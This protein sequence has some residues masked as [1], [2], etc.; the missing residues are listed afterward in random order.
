MKAKS[1]RIRHALF[2]C[3]FFFGFVDVS[4]GQAPYIVTSQGAG[5][6]GYLEKDATTWFRLNSNTYGNIYQL[7]TRTYINSQVIL[8]YGSSASNTCTTGEWST[9]N[10]NFGVNAIPGYLAYS[11]VHA[12][13][14][15]GGNSYNSIPTNQG[16]NERQQMIFDVTER[17][18]DLCSQ[19]VQNPGLRDN[20]VLSIKL[21]FGSIT[22]RTLTR[23]WLKNSGT[24]GEAGSDGIANNG[25]MVYY[26]A[27]TG[28][29]IYDGNEASAT[30]Y[31]NYN[32]N[33]TSNNE[34]GHDGL[35]INIPAGG[36]RIYVVLKQFA[37][38]NTTNKT[39]SFQILNDGLSFSPSLDTYTK[40]RSDDFPSAPT[41]ITKN[42]Q[43]TLD[44]AGLTSST[45]STMA[46]SARK[47]SSSYSG[48]ILR[49]YTGSN[50]YDVYADG[51]NSISLNSTISSSVANYNSAISTAT[52][53]LLSSLIT[54]GSNL[55]VAVWYDQSGNNRHVYQAANASRPKIVESGAITK[56]AFGN[57]A[58]KFNYSFLQTSQSSS[59]IAYSG[60]T[61]NSVCE[62]DGGSSRMFIGIDISNSNQGL[63]YGD[64]NSTTF[65]LNHYY[66]DASF[67]I[68]SSTYPRIRTAVKYN[69][70]GGSAAWLN[71]SSLGTNGNPG[72][73]LSPAYEPFNIGSGQNQS[74]SWYGY[75]AEAILFKIELSSTERQNLETNQLS[76]FS[77]SDATWTGAT[78]TDWNTASNWSP[79]AV[80]SSS[81]IINIPSVG[82]TNTPVVTSLTIDSGKSLTLQ[83]NAKLTISGTLTNNGTL[84]LKD[85][86]TLVQGTAGTSITGTGTYNV[87]K[88]L[89]GNSATW[90]STTSGRFWYMSVPMNSVA[91]SSFGTYGSTSNRVWS[92]AE[93]TKTY[94]EITGGSTA[95]VAGTGYVHRRTAD[96]TL[97]FTATGANG[98]FSSDF[99]LNNLSRTAGT[100]AGY[101]LIANPYMAYLDWDAVTKTNIDPTYYIRSN[102]TNDISA[103]ISYN[104]ST[105]QYTN[106]S[107]V[108][109]SGAADVRYIAPL[110]SI[111]IRVGTAS[112]TGSL[113]MTRSMLSHQSSNPGLKNTTVFPTLA[114]VNL[115]DGARFDQMLVF[116]NQDMSNA[117]DQ[118]DS[119]KM[120]VSGAPQI[121]TMAAGKKLVMN[122]LKNNKKKISV[123]LYLELPESKVYN[124]QLAE[125]ILEDGLILL[126]DKQ[127]GII[128]DFTIHDVYPFYAN[129]GVLSN[130]FVLHFFAPDN[131]ITAQGPSNS[132]V[133]NETSYTEGGQI[134]ISADGKGKVQITLD[135]PDA[136]NNQ[137]TV[138]AVDANGRVV[139]SGFLE[140]IT[141][142]IHLDVPS[143][144]YYL[145]VQ[146]GTLIEKKKV[147]IQE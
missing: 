141:T 99:T 44:L 102:N 35:S 105:Q 71:G 137:A 69:S 54:S 9:T 67:N 59:W 11:S 95:L 4:W 85:G 31:G 139:Y 27:A 88:A 80:P 25:I 125:Y 110:Q 18:S 103:L 86:A 58:L 45:F 133:E 26:E 138:Q 73:N 3:A 48:P 131:G 8:T 32:G 123:P 40:A 107:G 135:Q 89:S 143:G 23:L 14:C 147:F 39:V 114:R 1:L 64:C 98:L 29:E 100:A 22:N 142:E 134:V 121:Y 7:F 113:A 61:I 97:T 78:S 115:V 63:H 60:Y 2:L 104:S 12:Q 81:Q 68:T 37:A 21:D 50:Y 130:R 30:L 96:G 36:I 75:I 24:L 74:P 101:H 49:V 87:E 109:I 42:A 127:E 70:N 57:T 91:R 119:E 146:S 140:G 15:G 106:T 19:I 5:Q 118:Y 77:I 111:W 66:N 84:T 132:W 79:A 117:V 65:C 90:N 6:Y 129:S 62:I 56:D 122:G 38:A 76:Y 47:L 82:I 108:S 43:N 53:N 116:M 17:T 55:T 13:Y 10:Y 144:V 51:N 34:Y 145:S 72:A 52:S 94:S 128:Q 136:E 92:Y 120:F 33:S 20:V 124:L 83:A 16:F 46:Y 93:S 112:S 126:E 28:S 41:T